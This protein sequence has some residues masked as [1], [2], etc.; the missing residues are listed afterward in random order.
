MPN[1]MPGQI[2]AG[3]PNGLP[4]GP[5][6]QMSTQMPAATQI[7]AAAAVAQMPV[8]NAATLNA[9]EQVCNVWKRNFAYHMSLLRHYVPAFN[10]VTI[11]VKFPGII[12]RPIG[13]FHSTS[14]FHYQT[15]R[16]NIDLVQPLQLGLTLTDAAGNVPPGGNH[17]G[18]WQFNFKFDPEEA[19]C[20]T[21]GLEVLKLS[22]LDLNRHKTDGIDI[23]DFFEALTSSGLL[24]NPMVN[25]IT[26]YSGY[27]L[28]LLVSQLIN[29]A[30]PNEKEDYMELVRRFFPQ[31]WDVKMLVKA[32]NLSTKNYLHEIAEDFQ[33]FRGSSWSSAG[34][35]SRLTALCFYEILRSLGDVIFSVKN[36]LFG[37]EDEIPIGDEEAQQQ[38]L[39]QQLKN[40]SISN[41]VPNS[42]PGM[43]NAPMGTGPVAI[44]GAAPMN[45]GGTMGTQMGGGQSQSMSTTGM[46]PNAMPGAGAPPGMGPGG[47][48]PAM[49]QM[50]YMFNPAATNPQ[51]GS[52][53]PMYYPPR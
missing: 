38:M 37:L 23:A 41:V 33:L 21:E 1:Q 34:A 12:S 44:P 16:S 25:W 18:T 28:G 6:G 47:V 39:Q 49:M 46:G 51:V 19:M 26:F 48:P 24:M 10:F 13:T 43:P 32:F 14:E 20:S 15:L 27:D 17:V 36:R 8:P 31:V 42:M 22:G 3:L 30:V 45:L 29:T 35:D 40:T 7:P 53:Q 4:S 9:P 5:A 50:P 2:P 52:R 11:D